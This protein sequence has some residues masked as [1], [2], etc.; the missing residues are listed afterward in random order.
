MGEGRGEGFFP[1][2][3]LVRH[4]PPRD[5]QQPALE[6]ILS[7]LV[8]E[9]GHLLGRCNHY[10]LYD[11]LRFHFRQPGLE[12]CGVDEPPIRVEELAP[13]FL[14]AQVF[15]LREQAL[16]RRDGISVL[17]NSNHKWTANEHESFRLRKSLSCR[18]HRSADSLSACS[19]PFHI[20]VAADVRRL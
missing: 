18:R 7:R 16:A 19:L 20:F 2:P 11:F 12:R 1:L 15:E 9:A 17:H 14:V 8:G 13:T 5:A 10:L 4:L 3:K 6:R